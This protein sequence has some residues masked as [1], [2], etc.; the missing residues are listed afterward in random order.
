M[1]D[2]R[3]V[4]PSAVIYAAK[5]TQD[6]KG[7][8][9]TQLEDCREMCAENDWTVAAEFSDEGFSAYS[10]N[11]GPGLAGARE[12]A[13]EV[14][15]E[16]GEVV[17][18][19]A[20][21]SDRFSRGGGDKPGAAEALIEIW[22]HERRN[23]VH[24]RSVDDDFDLQTSVTVAN[25][26]ER[27]RSDSARKSKAVRRGMA[28]RRQGD[29]ENGVLPMHAGGTVY[30]Y[31]RDDAVG[32][33]EDPDQAAVVR[34]IFTMIAQGTPQAEVARTLNA[35]IAETGKPKPLRSDTWEQG[36]ISVMLRR[37][38][39]IGEVPADDWRKRE[40]KNIPEAWT[41]GAHEGIVSAELF[42]TANAA[43]TVRVKRGGDGGRRPKAGHLLTMGLLRHDCGSAMVPRSFER[44][45]NGSITGRYQCAGRKNGICSGLNV[46][47]AA[48]DEAILAYL[49]D[50]GI[51][52][53]ESVKRAQAARET[54]RDAAAAHLA[55]AEAAVIKAEAALKRVK[56]DYLSGAIEAGDWSEF[57]P[58]LEHAVGVALDRRDRIKEASL[59]TPADHAVPFVVDALALVRTA[60]KERNGDGVRQILR[61]LFEHFVI[62]D[63]ETAEEINAAS[64]PAAVAAG[65]ISESDVRQA[66]PDELAELEIPYPQPVE[67]KGHEILPIPRRAALA[68][69]IDGDNQIHL[70]D[71]SG[72]DVFRRLLVDASS[73]VNPL[74]M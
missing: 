66:E 49:A 56:A 43:N 44:Q 9:P 54:A 58:Q 27:N 17:M 14:A 30:G 5:S 60:A 50:V 22:H 36:S 24:L 19:V 47:M 11:R 10:G 26:G 41:Q 8:I 64:G 25:I 65:A 68:S 72:R 15:A 42:E 20:Q 57:R 2:N 21:H 18:L 1:C 6:T 29:P 62:L 13:A 23:D 40:N 63:N 34:R 31:A 59:A 38:T 32:L 4:N 51:D 67:A 55:E 28:R 7:S 39:Y 61:D 3:Y 48:V 33:I 73:Y 53:E 46:E 71:E 16:T 12:R 45:K 74:Q 37:R 69:L 70:V 52:A 35:E